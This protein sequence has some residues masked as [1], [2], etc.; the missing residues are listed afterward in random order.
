MISPRIYLQAAAFC[1]H[2]LTENDNVSSLIRIVDQLFV[3]PTPDLPLDQVGIKIRMYVSF[4]S[5]DFEGRR[6][7]RIDRIAPD[8]SRD[9]IYDGDLDFSGDGIVRGSNVQGDIAISLAKG[10][11]LYL[12]EIYLEDRMMTTMPLQINFNSKPGPDN[13]D[14]SAETD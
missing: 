10:T 12:F 9:S 6:S 3:A 5:I 8:G 13:E 7:F 2:V 14:Q 1:E 4:K 11:G